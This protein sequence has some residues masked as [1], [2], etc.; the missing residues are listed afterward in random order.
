MIVVKSGWLKKRCSHP[1]GRLPATGRSCI[2]CSFYHLR[3]KHHGHQ[4]KVYITF[5][6][7]SL[8]L[9]GTYKRNFPTFCQLKT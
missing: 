3:G 4:A 7:A 6:P 5:A 2:R 9:V 1:L 8:K